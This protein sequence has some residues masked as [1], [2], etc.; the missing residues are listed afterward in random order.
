MTMNKRGI[1]TLAL[2]AFALPLAFAKDAPTTGTLKVHAIPD[3]AGVYVDGK[4]LGPAANFG[5]TRKYT[6]AVGDHELKISDPRYEDLTQKITISA[7]KT[8]N[9]EAKL[10]ALD[11]PK[12]PYG[13]LR[14]TGADKYA[15]VYLTGKYMGHA[16]EFNNPFQKLSVPPGSYDLKVVSPA[17][18]AY[19]EKITLTADK[20]TVVKVK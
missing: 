11:M 18:K 5:M 20:T 16:G 4:H 2:L 19:E 7:G 12:P 15:E 9:I 17:G 1:V 10:K 8:T 13:H 14:V 6:V 3:H